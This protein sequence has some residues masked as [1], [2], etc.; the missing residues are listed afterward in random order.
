MKSRL[1]VAGLVGVLLLLAACSTTGGVGTPVAG[2]V[3]VTMTVSGPVTTVLSTVVTTVSETT[4]VTVEVT[5]PLTLNSRVFDHVKVEAG[6]TKILT[7]AAPNGYGLQGVSGISC[8]SDQPVKV[9][10]KFTCTG[11]VGGSQR[12]IT[13]TVKDDAGRYEVAP[14]S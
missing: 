1:T 8:P 5:H 7:D 6:V 14:P 11:T 3:R 10:A 4:T 9:G 12:Q 13:I 2:A